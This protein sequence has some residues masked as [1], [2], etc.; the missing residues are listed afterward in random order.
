MRH[1][2]NAHVFAIVVVVVVVAVVAA[3]VAVC[4][5]H[6]AAARV[7]ASQLV[8]HEALLDAQSIE[9]VVG[10]HRHRR[11]GRRGRHFMI[12]LI[13][14]EV[15]DRV[16]VV[17]HVAIEIAFGQLHEL[18]ASR[19]CLGRSGAGGCR[20]RV[21]VELWPKLVA[22][23]GRVVDEQHTLVLFVVVGVAA[24]AA[25]RRRRRRRHRD[26]IRGELLLDGRRGHVDLGR[27]ED[28]YR[29]GIGAARCRHCRH[30]HSRN[31]SDSCCVCQGRARRETCRLVATGWL[32][33]RR[34][35]RAECVAEVLVHFGR[36]SD[37]LLS[38]LIVAV[39]R[40]ESP[41]GAHRSGA[42]STRI[43]ESVERARGARGTR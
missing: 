16:V 41:L 38:E 30:R 25:R 6:I 29:T 40:V 27:M 3:A 4:C 23:D 10:E 21:D 26:D 8:E 7:C 42:H 19:P 2:A 24:S 18:G 5:C 32:F 13:V 39:G 34:R 31:R 9:A 11:R 14:V 33:S 35:R 36:S 17:I 22:L 20:C 1:F 12:A 37:S 43:L 28:V 15:V